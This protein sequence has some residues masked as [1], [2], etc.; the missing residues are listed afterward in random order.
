MNEV[1]TD[2]SFE[3]GLG[4]HS[5]VAGDDLKLSAKQFMMKKK[6][7]SD[8]ERITCLAFYLTHYKETPMFKTI[9]LTHLNI[10]AAQP[11]MTNPTVAAKNAVAAQ[12]LVLVGG[13]KRQLGPRGEAVVN[14]L[15]DR[16]KVTEALA[17]YPLHGRK[18]TLKK[19]TK[20]N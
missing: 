3:N 14:A 12:Y 8:V 20:T 2:A 15:P 7:T 4:S 16:S 10:E 9:D 18:K 13:A 17:E 19:R 5:D 1:S 6:P 11:R